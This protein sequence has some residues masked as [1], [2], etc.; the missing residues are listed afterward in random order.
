[1]TEAVSYAYKSSLVSRADTFAVTPAGLSWTIRRRSGL[2][3][4]NEIASVRLSFRPISMQARRFRADITSQNGAAIAIVS[5]SWQTASLMTTQDDSYRAFLVALHQ[6]LKEAGGTAVL[7]AGLRPRV[8]AM[9]V[10]LF[11]LAAL[12][13]LALLLRAIWIGEWAGVAFLIAFAALFAWKV[14]GFIRRNRPRRYA[15][16]D[17]PKD[18]MP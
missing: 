18:L 10:S 3:R 7:S 1:M 13:M 12:L 4:Y 2:W 8:F 17:F 15:L 11:A 9:A 14:G 5:T 6:Q 16:D